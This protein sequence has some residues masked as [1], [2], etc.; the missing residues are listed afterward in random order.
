MLDGVDI[1]TFFRSIRDKLER[2]EWVP[3]PGPDWAYELYEDVPELEEGAREDDA[4]RDGWPD[5]R[6]REFKRI[7][8]R[9]G[10]PGQGYNKDGCLKAIRDHCETLTI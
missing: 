2:L 7:Y 6:A 3:V 5:P 10:W 8:R 9:F 1:A 4:E